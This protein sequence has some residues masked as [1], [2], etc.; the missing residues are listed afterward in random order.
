MPRHRTVARSAA[1]SLAAGLAAPAA[2]QV[3][4]YDTLFITNNSLTDAG[5]GNA[6]GGARVFPSLGTLDTQLA[7]DFEV[8]NAVTITL[9]TVDISTFDPGDIPDEGFRV[10]FYADESGV[11]SETL[12][13]ETISTTWTSS[14]LPVVASR[15]AARY[16]IDISSANIELATGVWWM[17]V[18]PM[19]EAHGGWFWSSARLNLDPQIGNLAHV[20][21]GWQAHGTTHNGLWNSTTWFPHNFRGFGTPARKIEG[22]FGSI[23]KPDLTSTAVP[24]QPGYGIPNGVLNNDDFFYF[25]A[26]FSAGNL[27]VAD[28]TTGAVPGAPGYGVPNGVINNDDFFYYLAIFTASC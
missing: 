8:V 12:L 14:P 13:A 25:L 18:Q 7:D 17:D 10:Q 20:R 3:V 23:C 6:I 22:V 28:M 5:I 16:V 24:G 2:A 4:L 21:D 9:V 11:P 1:L 26:Q 27:A 15:E 19:D